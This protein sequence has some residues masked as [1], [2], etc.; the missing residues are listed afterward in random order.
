MRTIIVKILRF[1]LLIVT[2]NTCSSQSI[3]TN[4][5]NYRFIKHKVDSIK[6]Y[7]IIFKIDTNLTQILNEL[8]SKSPS[9]YSRITGILLQN[10]KLNSA[11]IVHIVGKI[12]LQYYNSSVI[13][14]MTEEEQLLLSM[15]YMFEEYLNLYLKRNID[16][17]IRATQEAVNYCKIYDYSHYSRKNN[18]YEYNNVITDYEKHLTDIKNEKQKYSLKWENEIQELIKKSIHSEP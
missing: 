18:P 7:S 10:E 16:Y 2:I 17:Y 9:E 14:K 1:F 11:S 15:S 12:R 3:D 8:D 6:T 5:F 13:T 4:S